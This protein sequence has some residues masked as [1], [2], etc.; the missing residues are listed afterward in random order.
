MDS[1]L[2]KRV[3]V[4]VEAEQSVLGSLLIDPAEGFEKISG[5]LSSDD[6]YINE[7]RVLFLA[8]QEMFLA[9]Q[10]IDTVTLVNKLVENGDRDEG[11]GLQY[12]TQIAEIVP[13]ARNIKDYALIVRDKALLRRLI[14]VSGNISDMAYSEQGKATDLIDVAE[15]MV[16][17]LAEKRQSNQLR[18]IKDIIGEVYQNIVRLSEA[19]EADDGVK[20]GFSGLDRVLVQLGKGDLVLV[21]A[22]PGIGKTS[23]AMNIAINYAKKETSK[24]VCVFSLEMSCEQIVNRMLSSEA[25]VDSYSLRS[26][27]ISPD[28]WVRLADAASSLAG[29]NILI[30]D[31]SSITVAD[32]KA[33]LRRVKNLGLVLVDYLQLMQST[34]KSDNRVQQVAEISRNLKIMAKDLGVPVVCC[35][36]LSRGPESRTDKK[37]MLSDLR[38]S[39]SIEQDADIVMFLYRPEYYKDA[40]GGEAAEPNTAEVI[41]AKNRHGAVGNVKMGWIGQ[42][43]KF[44]TLESDLQEPV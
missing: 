7:H 37:P 26:G 41:V 11:G 19:G 29:C 5:I 17:D 42:F 21:G 10:E 25:L 6:F 20:T 28:D 15:Q 35:A 27:Q 23:F 9:N 31:T 40:E 3:P 33:K 30:D 44:R 43:T 16:F 8:M 38:D 34:V 18:S 36:Q 14:D 32:M 24:T 4:S 22:R 1:E 12:I 39:G 13:S 2:L